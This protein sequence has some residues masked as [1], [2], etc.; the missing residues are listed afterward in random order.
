MIY[1]YMGVCTVC[2]HF[3]SSIVFYS[4]LLLL[5][6]AEIRPRMISRMSCYVTSLALDAHMN[7][8]AATPCWL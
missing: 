7:S 8:I 2:D 6:I 3:A 1:Y 4:E 5:E